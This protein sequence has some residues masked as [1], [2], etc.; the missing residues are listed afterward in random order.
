MAASSANKQ[1]FAANTQNHQFSPS[2]SGNRGCT[3]CRKPYLPS[4]SIKP[5]WPAIAPL[6]VTSRHVG[7]CQNILVKFGK[8]T[9]PANTVTQG[10]TGCRQAQFTMVASTRPCPFGPQLLL[11]PAQPD[12]WA[13]SCGGLCFTMRG[14]SSAQCP[15][16]W[17]KL[18]LSSVLQ[19]S[20]KVTSGKWKLISAII[21]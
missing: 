5:F 21:S 1:K 15:L 12:L 19:V 2:P 9:S 11:C 4:S 8:H 16:V 3:G 17:C 20:H 18:S 7:F 13:K 14:C 6:Q 10:C